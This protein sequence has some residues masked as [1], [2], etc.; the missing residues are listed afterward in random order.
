MGKACFFAHL[1]QPDGRREVEEPQR[2]PLEAHL[3]AAEVTIDVAGL[4]S[5]REIFFYLYSGKINALFRNTTTG[6]LTLTLRGR[7]V[8]LSSLLFLLLLPPPRPFC[9][10]VRSSLLLSSH[11]VLSHIKRPLSLGGVSPAMS[12]ERRGAADIGVYDP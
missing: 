11:P 12:R 1:K 3:V 4:E 8:L 9:S 6:R 2:D 7:E 10:F 5:E